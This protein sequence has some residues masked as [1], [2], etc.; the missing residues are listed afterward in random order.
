MRPN[1]VNLLNAI[2]LQRWLKIESC[3]ALF[4]LHVDV[5]QTTSILRHSVFVNNENY[6]DAPNMVKTPFLRSQMLDYFAKEAA[7]SIPARAESQ[8]RLVLAQQRRH[9][10]EGSNFERLAT[11]VLGKCRTNFIVPRQKGE[12]GSIGEDQPNAA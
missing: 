2:G 9:L 1:L 8:R 12:K 3:E 4:G 5:V 10:G 6:N 7:Q 11:P